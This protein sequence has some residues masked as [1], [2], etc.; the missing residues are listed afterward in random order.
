MDVVYDTLED[1]TNQIVRG[2]EIAWVPA[3]DVFAAVGD[4]AEEGLE[5]WEQLGMIEFVDCVRFCRQEVRLGVCPAHG[6]G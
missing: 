1:L 4:E 6:V 2:D 3:P 5:M